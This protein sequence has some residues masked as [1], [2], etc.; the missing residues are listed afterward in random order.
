MGKD[1]E[2]IDY[3]HDDAFGN[4]GSTGGPDGNEASY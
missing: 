3:R 1:E 2:D 4:S